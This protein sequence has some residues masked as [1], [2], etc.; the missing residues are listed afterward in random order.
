LLLVVEVLLVPLAMFLMI[1]ATKLGPVS[2]VATIVG[3]RPVFIL[4]YGTVLSLPRLR[5]LNES[6]DPK[7]LAIKTASVAMIIGGIVSLSLFLNDRFGCFC[8]Y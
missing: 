2:L 8:P 5:I 1:A 7:A 4:L 3:T 6:L